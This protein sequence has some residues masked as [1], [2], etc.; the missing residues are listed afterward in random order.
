MSIFAKEEGCDE[1]MEQAN[2]S[3]TVD[4]KTDTEIEI[5]TEVSMHK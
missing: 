5:N 1:E 4:D 2:V 3:G